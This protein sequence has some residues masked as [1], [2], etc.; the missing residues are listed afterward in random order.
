MTPKKMIVLT[1]I[2]V[3]VMA[4]AY[5]T[6][7]VV[8]NMVSRELDAVAGDFHA[9][10]SDAYAYGQIKLTTE[11]QSFVGGWLISVQAGENT[12]GMILSLNIDRTYLQV[13]HNS[14]ESS[15]TWCVM[16]GNL[17]FARTT[18]NGAPDNETTGEAYW[19]WT[20]QPTANPDIYNVTTVG[21][22]YSNGQYESAPDG[23]VITISRIG[24]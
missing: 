3:G 9:A 13:D 4:V 16:K 23:L 1:L 15:G 6:V 2:I 14:D 19:V 8:C 21:K 12:V 24:A 18:I 11:E 10:L 5:A 7:S 22:I 20:L 17:L